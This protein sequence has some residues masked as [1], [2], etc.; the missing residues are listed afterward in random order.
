M[1]HE[2][3]G[4]PLLSLVLSGT[5]RLGPGVEAHAP[6]AQPG[7]GSGPGPAPRRYRSP[8]AIRSML[9]RTIPR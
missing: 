7:E 5:L 9:W 1:P 3:P 8:A 6:L 2:S 4:I